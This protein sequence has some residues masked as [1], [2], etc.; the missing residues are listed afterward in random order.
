MFCVCRRFSK[1]IY[2]YELEGD[3]V[4]FIHLGICEKRTYELKLTAGDGLGLPRKWNMK[5]G[6]GAILC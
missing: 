3:L 5:G 1:I 2:E 6:K 4:H